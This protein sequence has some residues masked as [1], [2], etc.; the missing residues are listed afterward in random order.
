MQNADDAGAQELKFCLDHRTHP[1]DTLAYGKLATFQGPSLLAF[2]NAQ[3]TEVDFKSIQRI[4]DSLKKTSSKGAK[5]GRFGVGFN[6]VYHLTDLPTFVS[7]K[8]L[9]MFD[10]QA[11]HL[12]DVN[13]SNPGKMINFQQHS[14]LIQKFPDQFT[15]FRAFGCDLRSEFKG[16]LFRLPLRTK[17]GLAVLCIGSVS[18]HFLTSSPV[19]TR[20]NTQRLASS[21]L[22]A[23]LL[24][25]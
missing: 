4:G 6:S 12:P 5:T 23:T 25:M 8:F 10:P 20:R 24:M 9:V 16:T 2:N 22:S 17:V 21:L 15:P 13:P 3:F 18:T 1:H 14:S 19:H 11:S 7:G